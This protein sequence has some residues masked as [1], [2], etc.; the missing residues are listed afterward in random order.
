M[1]Q[2]RGQAISKLTVVKQGALRR[3]SFRTACVQMMRE[4]QLL[5]LVFSS[6]AYDT[7]DAPNE[8]DIQM[9]VR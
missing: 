3:D 2:T 6:S 9:A 8:Q 4:E 1:P 5:T 7:E